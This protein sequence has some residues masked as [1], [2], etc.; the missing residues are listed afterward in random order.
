MYTGRRGYPALQAEA[1]HTLGL[2]DGPS[3]W[4]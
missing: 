2:I 1:S 4:N 3:K